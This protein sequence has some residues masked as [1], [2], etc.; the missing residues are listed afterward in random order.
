MKPEG[1][2]FEMGEFS[3]TGERLISN[4]EFARNVKDPI[5]VFCEARLELLGS[6]P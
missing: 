5:G 3:E 1:D 2:D 6:V 4:E